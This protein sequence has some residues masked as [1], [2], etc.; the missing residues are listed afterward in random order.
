MYLEAVHRESTPLNY[1][2]FLTVLSLLGW[3]G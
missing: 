2:L 1:L 3:L